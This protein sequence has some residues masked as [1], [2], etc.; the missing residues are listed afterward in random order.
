MTRSE[1]ESLIQLQEDIAQLCDSTVKTLEQ[2]LHQLRTK[3]MLEIEFHIKANRAVAKTVRA[4]I[5][6]LTQFFPIDKES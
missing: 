2:E 3:A 1:I 6:R 4:T 5:T